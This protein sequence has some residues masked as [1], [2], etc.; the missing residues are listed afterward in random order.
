MTVGELLGLASSSSI[1]LDWAAFYVP[2]NT[3]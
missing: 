3:V 1:G 2:A